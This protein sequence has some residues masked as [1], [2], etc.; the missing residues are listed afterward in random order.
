VSQ[1][2]STDNGCEEGTFQFLPWL[3]MAAFE[4]SITLPLMRAQLA[5]I[6]RQPDLTVAQALPTFVDLDMPPANLATNW[7]E[8]S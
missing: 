7:P 2:A 3:Q 1:W 4:R 8:S 6:D 5:V